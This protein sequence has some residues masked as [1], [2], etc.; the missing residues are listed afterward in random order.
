MEDEIGGID[1]RPS[2]RWTGADIVGVIF[3]WALCQVVA[4]A[5]LDG[6]GWFGWYYGDSSPSAERQSL[7]TTMLTG[8]L[9]IPATLIWLRLSCGATLADLGLTTRRLGRNVAAGLLF[10]LIFA[11]G[12]YGI[13]KLALLAMEA[14]GVKE[15][16]HMFTQLWQAGLR[17]EEWAL[18]IGAAV[19]LAPLWEELL[20]RGVVQPW[21]MA[22]QPWGGPAALGAALFMTLASRADQLRDAIEKGA[23]WGVELMPLVALAATVPVYLLVNRR[24]P[25]AAGLFATA[26]LFAWVHARV[27]PTPI[28]L[29]WLAL[30][31]GW[32]RW[33]T[34]SLVGCMVMHA[35]FNAVAVLTLLWW[36]AS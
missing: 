1:D 6:V 32:L 19:V 4:R 31:F 34:A 16:P 18:L 22:R 30:G 8:A 23:G 21:A 24:S 7:W 9:Q 13:H 26:V 36:K 33:K 27:W 25:E 28:P 17:P 15:Q 2:P 11:P 14:L 12:T 5:W 20:F 29:L 10:A 3:L 35:A